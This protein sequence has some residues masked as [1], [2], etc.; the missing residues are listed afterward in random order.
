MN[1]ILLLFSQLCVTLCYPMD[2]SL[3]GFPVLHCLLEFAQT[4][5]HWV[6]DAIQPPHHLSPTSPPALNLSQHQVTFPIFSISSSNIYSWLIS[7][8]I[9]WFDLAVQGTLK[10]LLQH[11]SSKTILQFSTFF[12]VQLSHPHITTGRIITLN[13]QSFFSKVICLLFNILS[14]CIIAFLPRIKCLL[15]FWLQSLSTMI[16]EP[17]KIKSITV[18]IFTHLF[19]VKWW[20]WMLWSSFF[21][22]WV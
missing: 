6:D 3:L 16:L 5:V 9:D 13:I 15:I 7:F 2:C 18:S 20:D 11:H 8:R 21:K 19:A 22:C 14:M 1:F 10:S 4:H 12:K 17:K